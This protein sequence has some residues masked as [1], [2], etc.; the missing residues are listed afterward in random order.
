MDI[1][2]TPTALGGIVLPDSRSGRSVDLGT[3]PPR[4]VLSVIRHRH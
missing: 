1:D 4:A 3:E 2:P